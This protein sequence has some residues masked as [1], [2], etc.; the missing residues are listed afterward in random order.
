MIIKNALWGGLFTIVLGIPFFDGEFY[1]Y[2]LF[3][4]LSIIGMIGKMRSNVNAFDRLNRQTIKKDKLYTFPLLM[5]FIWFF[6]IVIGLING[7]L[8]SNIIR[9]FAGTGCYLFFYLLVYKKPV[10]KVVLLKALNKASVIAT[11]FT[12][13]AF[14]TKK[15]EINYWPFNNVSFNVWSKNLLTPVEVLAFILEAVSIW[16]IF[17]EKSRQGKKI[18]FIIY[19][20]LASYVL[21]F[22]NSMGGF[23]LGY[24]AILGVVVF[25][26]VFFNPQYR[27]KTKVF[28]CL[29]YIL[30]VCFVIIYDLNHSNTIGEI[31]SLTDAGN[32]KRFYQLQLVVDRFR[33]LG[34]GIGS[35]ME[36]GYGN[37][38]FSSYGIE[39]SY[40][41]VI[42]KYGLLSLLVFGV[43][44]KTILRA[45]RG[46]RAKNRNSELCIMVIGACGYMFVA[47]GNPVLFSAYNV[48]LHSTVLYLLTNDRRMSDEYYKEISTS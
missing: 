36:Y 13:C 31:F 26:S 28:T 30:I 16:K 35:V 3:L 11:I 33:L 48:I 25:Y 10:S 40:L 27:V 38:A 41:N 44:I 17:G 42:D 20:V 2:F 23:K 14:Q 7:N 6:G 43:Y 45:L 46:L 12:I 34:N 9:N 47:I 4:F 18:K 29:C 5:I 22:T 24:I 37:A 32:T 8:I 15:W 21:L 1:Y 19:F 39:V